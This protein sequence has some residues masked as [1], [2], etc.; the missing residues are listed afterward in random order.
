MDLT[1]LE[2]HLDDA[3]FSANAPFAG[4][5]DH[6]ESDSEPTG[7]SGHAAEG[8]SVAPLVVGLVVLAVAALAARKLLGG[9]SGEIESVADAKSE[10]EAVAP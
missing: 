7:E 8:R 9:D 6:D 1:I 3:S 4:R 2:V 5:E 10:A